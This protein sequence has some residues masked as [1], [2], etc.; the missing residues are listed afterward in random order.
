MKIGIGSVI[1]GSPNA[2]LDDLVNEVKAAEADGFAFFS[3][4][5]IFGLDAIS[6]LTIAGRE[7][8]KIELATGVTPT[9]PRHPFAIA[10]QA[11]TAQAACKGRFVL[12]I[13]LSHKIVIENM[14]GLSY[15]HPAKQM[16]EYLEVLMPLAQGKPASF[17]GDLYRVNG[18]LQ[19]PGGTPLPVVVAA[20]GP[21]MLEVTGRLA[22]GTATWMTGAKT[23]AEHTVPTINKAAKEAGKPA[24]RVIAAL[25][26]A[27]TDDPRGL[28]DVANNVF[29]IY[30]QLPSYRAMLDRE[31]AAT[32][33]DVGILGD[34]SVLRAGLARLRDAGVT[35]FLASVFGDAKT[36]ERT[37]AFLKS[38]L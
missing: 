30:G 15:A 18:A 10:Q 5:N 26:F 12:G 3:L 1:A 4:P 13:G 8:K 33:G 28:R 9:P 7:T 27:L 31:G 2:T 35:H 19:I 16:R 24:P 25:P 17:S 6:A 11:L 23:L 14:L 36:V 32:P 38:E 22:D 34:E 21:K 37:K 20:L 29:A